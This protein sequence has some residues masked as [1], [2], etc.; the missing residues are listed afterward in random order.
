MTTTRSG[1][2]RDYIHQLENVHAATLIAHGFNDWNVVPE[3]STRIYEALKANGIPLK[4]FLHQGGHGG[5]PPFVLRN[6]WFTRFLYGVDNGVEG[7]A[8]AWVVREAASC[9]PRTATVVG[10]Q[11]NTTTLTV[12][13]TSQLQLGFVLTIPQTS[14]TGTIT[15]T[16]RTINSI[17]DTNT[18]V[19]SAAVATGTGQ[20]IA[21]GAI[22]SHVCNSSNPTPYA[23]WPNP[24]TFSVPMQVKA[25]GATSGSFTP[26][27]LGDPVTETIIDDWNCGTA[28]LANAASS[29]TRLL[30]KTPVL[31]AP[32]HISGTPT[33][34]CPACSEQGGRQSLDRTRQVAL[35]RRVIVHIR[36]PGNHD[37][38][39]HS[40]LGGP[41]ERYRPVRH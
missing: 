9:P 39:G 31:D 17:P 8:N 4:V 12:D 33:V 37:E 40:R 7:T 38:R 15:T 23:D 22:V 13:N 10:D 3:H 2:G 27:A 36:D 25:G 19:L 29:T 5:A 34:D 1:L 28:G 26:L 30:Y 35:E 6:L 14:S 16:T 11:S 32:L 20:F 18:V 24:S 21:N 41:Q